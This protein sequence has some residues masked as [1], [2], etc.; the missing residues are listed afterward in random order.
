MIAISIYELKDIYV[1]KEQE[2]P[3]MHHRLSYC[4]KERE[5]ADFSTCTDP[6]LQMLNINYSREFIDIVV[7]KIQFLQ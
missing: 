4:E 5:C 2:Y 7:G 6:S 1:Q 3:G